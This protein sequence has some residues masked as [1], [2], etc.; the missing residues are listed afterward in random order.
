MVVARTERLLPLLLLVAGCSQPAK[1]TAPTIVTLHEGTPVQLILLKPLESGVA[2]SGDPIPLMV[3]E[4]VRDDSG[5][6][7]IAKGSP[8]RGR[9][10]WSRRA[11]LTS[12]VTNRPARL[13]IVADEAT[14]V[15]GQAIILG[16]GGGGKGEAIAFTRAN[17]GDSLAGAALDALW[18]DADSRAFIEKL[19]EG[20]EKGDWGDLLDSKGSA[21]ILQRV[22]DRVGM[23]ETKALVEKNEVQRAKSVLRDV[24]AGRVAQGLVG[25]ESAMAIAA[26]AELAKLAGGVG[27]RLSRTLDAPNIR[28]PIGTPIKVYVAQDTMVRAPAKS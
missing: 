2:K 26:V 19:N 28:A 7:L 22:A 17:V 21:D 20:I 11:D 1:P 8:A 6:L 5:V 9:V 23:P 16:A 25:G 15:D 10:T 14:A 4:D 12:L 13:E 3:A 27:S 18:D 24:T